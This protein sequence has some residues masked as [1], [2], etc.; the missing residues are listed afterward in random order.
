MYIQRENLLN[1]LIRYRH[2]DLVKIITG[3]R[4]CGKSILLN[5]LFYRY[6]LDDKV[7]ADHILKIAFD[8]KKWQNLRK[9]DELYSYLLG[10]FTD[11][12]KYYLLL[13]EI[14]MVEGFE[15][16]LN[17]VRSEYNTD[18]YVTGSNSKLLSSDINTIFRGRGIEIKCFPLSFQEFYSFRKGDKREALDE[19]ILFGSLPYTVT[20]PDTPA[21]RSYLEMVANTVITMD[22]IDHYD[23]RNEEVFRGVIHVLCSSIGSSVSPNK[24]ANTLQSSGYKSVDHET[25][26]RYLRHIVDAFLFYKVERY[27]LKGRAYLKTQSKYYACDMG[28]RNALIQYR[29]LEVSRAIANIVYV[30]LIR[31]G[32]IVDIGKNRNEE[33]DFVARD[34]EGRKNYIQVTY[35]IENPSVKERE[36]SSFYGLDDGHK[37]ILITMDKTPFSNLER[38]YRLLTVLDFLENDDS[39]EKA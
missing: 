11:D 28:L 3:V 27:D 17:E 4:R 21:K 30:E 38:G 33:I 39:I 12:K 26:S 25:V 18:I 16:V 14:Q 20:E 13:D 35:S 23:I 6:L 29:Q 8:M 32:Y 34:A 19:Y 10:R 37:K 7:Q 36:L 1:T 31:R 24:I 5:E 15:E 22:M 2:K 9:S